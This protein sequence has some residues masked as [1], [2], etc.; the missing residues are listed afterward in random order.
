MAIV[1][2]DVDLLVDFT[3]DKKQL[4]DKLDLILDRV[5]DKQLVLLED[6]PSLARLGRSR[7]T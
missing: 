3:S 2:D 1:T 6:S 7:Q 5:K 4:K